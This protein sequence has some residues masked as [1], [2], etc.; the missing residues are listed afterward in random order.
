MRPRRRE[1][2]KP[3]MKS[4]LL[5][6]LAFAGLLMVA[7]PLTASATDQATCGHKPAWGYQHPNWWRGWWQKNCSWRYGYGQNRNYLQNYYGNR[8]QW[9]PYTWS[10]PRYYND[11]DADDGY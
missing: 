7:M 5:A 10:E 4:R 11:H 3:I 9:V 8:G 2:E 6:M 1:K